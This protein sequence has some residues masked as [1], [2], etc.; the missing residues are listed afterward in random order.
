MGLHHTKT[1]QSSSTYIQHQRLEYSRTIKPIRTRSQTCYYSAWEEIA[2][3][4]HDQWLQ[5]I[6]GKISTNHVTVFFT[7]LYLFKKNSVLLHMHFNVMLNY[8]V[9]VRL[10][11]VPHLFHINYL[12][13]HDVQ[14]KILVQWQVKHFVNISNT[15]I[16][17]P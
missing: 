5:A 3:C 6:S 8:I 14:R 17:Q 9:Y 2:R 4:S 7:H 15:I 16:S 13:F 1:D 10:V 11:S 12:V